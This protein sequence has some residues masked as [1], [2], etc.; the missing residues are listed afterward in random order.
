MTMA[1]YCFMIVRVVWVSFS[2]RNG[3][4]GRWVGRGP[5]AVGRGR[6]DGSEL[7]QRL[8]LVFREFDATTTP[9]NN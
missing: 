6:R 3:R 5:W 1:E 4:S 9:T 2:K 7:R 8:L